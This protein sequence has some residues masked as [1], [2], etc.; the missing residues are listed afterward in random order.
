MAVV[1]RSR[2]DLPSSRPAL[3]AGLVSVAAH[4]AVV[5]R[6]EGQMAADKIISKVAK[7]LSTKRKNK[8]A[9]KS[10]FAKSKPG[11]QSVSTQPSR[12]APR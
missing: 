8:L 4:D 12:S 1:G 11:G 9:R 5:D 7:R 10:K 2:T 3:V 6:W